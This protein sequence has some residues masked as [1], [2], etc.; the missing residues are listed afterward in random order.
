MSETSVPHHRQLI[1]TYS[2]DVMS[3]QHVRRWC[4]EIKNGRKNIHVDDRTG[5]SSTPRK[6][7]IGF[8]KTGESVGGDCRFHVNGTVELAVREWLRMQEP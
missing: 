1:Q 2:D 5:R 4:T 3:L 8:S 6:N 7:V